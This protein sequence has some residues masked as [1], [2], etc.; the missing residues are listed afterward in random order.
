MVLA[1]ELLEAGVRVVR[2]AREKKWN[3]NTKKNI[4]YDLSKNM[5]LTSSRFISFSCIYIHLFFSGL[6]KNVKDE[7]NFEITSPVGYHKI[8]VN[9]DA[10]I[11]KP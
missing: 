10:C 5:S 1:V 4:Q 6:L 3:K 2:W 11:L 7:Y 8:Q 9:F